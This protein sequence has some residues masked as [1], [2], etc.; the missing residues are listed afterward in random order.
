LAAFSIGSK[1]RAIPET[2]IEPKGGRFGKGPVL[3]YF[4]AKKWVVI[5]PGGLRERQKTG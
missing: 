4:I 2:N 5:P 1:I 3:M